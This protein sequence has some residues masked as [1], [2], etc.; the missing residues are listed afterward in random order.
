MAA[1]Y[2]CEARNMTSVLNDINL[3]LRYSEKQQKSEVNESM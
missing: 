3:N 1:Q 2:D